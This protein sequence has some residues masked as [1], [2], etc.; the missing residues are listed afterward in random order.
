M[1]ILV[2]LVIKEILDQLEKLGQLEEPDIL[3]LVVVL[4]GLESS[5]KD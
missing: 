2:Q 4:E 5:D 3:V 1:E